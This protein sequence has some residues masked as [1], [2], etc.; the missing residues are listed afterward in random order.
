MLNC[1]ISFRNDK[2]TDG[3][4]IHQM[5]GGQLLLGRPCLFKNYE[6]FKYPSEAEF[7][8]WGCI[9]NWDSKKKGK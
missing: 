8:K 1:V 5:E 7:S 9:G 4:V 6:E 3:E 2:T